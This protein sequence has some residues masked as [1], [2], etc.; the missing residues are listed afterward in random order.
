MYAGDL[1]AANLDGRNSLRLTAGQAI[2]TAPIFS[3]D[4]SLG[5]PPNLEVEQTPVKI[6]RA[7]IS[8]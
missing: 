1:W 7:T 4:G 5:I 8:S 6:F 3:P 2:P